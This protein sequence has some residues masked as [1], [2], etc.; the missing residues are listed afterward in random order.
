[1]LC[2]RELVNMQCASQLRLHKTTKLAIH[3]LAGVTITADGEVLLYQILECPPVHIQH[4]VGIGVDQESGVENRRRWVE[5]RGYTEDSVF[6]GYACPAME[7][8]FHIEYVAYCYIVVRASKKRSEHT[9][10]DWARRV[11]EVFSIKKSGESCACVNHSVYNLYAPENQSLATCRSM[12][13]NE[14]PLCSLV[15]V[16]LCFIR[17]SQPHPIPQKAQGRKHVCQ[18]KTPL[19]L[20]SREFQKNPVRGGG[21]DSKYYQGGVSLFWDVGSQKIALI[22]L[23]MHLGSLSALV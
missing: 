22:A 11:V 7:V 18:I 19:V 17:L 6:K 4:I 23:S 14:N 12:E 5:P 13:Y 10:L 16:L 15:H 3:K 1:M 20:K 9:T 21:R 2:S 8:R